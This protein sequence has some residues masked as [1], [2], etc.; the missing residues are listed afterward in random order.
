MLN[1]GKNAQQ[2]L[3][4]IGRVGNTEALRLLGL[5]L[6]SKVFELVKESLETKNFFVN[7]KL[8]IGCGSGGITGDDTGNVAPSVDAMGGQDLH[9]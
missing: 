2:N 3:I 7:L 6:I 5:W 1:K 4:V 9:I 8:E